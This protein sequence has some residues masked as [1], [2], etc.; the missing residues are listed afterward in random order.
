[1]LRRIMMKLLKQGLTRQTRVAA[2]AAMLCSIGICVAYG[3]E[4]VPITM[5]KLADDITVL[6][7]MIYRNEAP[8]DPATRARIGQQIDSMLDHVSQVQQS[9]AP[10]SD[11]YRISYQTLIMQLQQA[12]QELAK[13]RERHGI[14]L[15][16][17]ATS[18]CATCHMQ[19]ERSVNWLTPLRDEMND[20]F[21]AG[22]Y[23]FMTRQYERASSAYLSLL[24]QQRELEYD[25][26][27][28][29]AVDR[30]LVTSLQMQKDPQLLVKTLWELTEREHINPALR[31]DLSDWITGIAQLQQLTNIREHPKPDT[32]V[33]M[34]NQWINEGKNAPLGRIF[35]S[36]V[37]RPQIVWLRGELYHTLITATEREKIASLLYWL[38]LCDRVLEYRFYY[39]LADMYLKQCMLEYTDTPTAQQCYREYENYIVFSYSGSSGSNIPP[40]VDDEL[41]KLKATVF[42]IQS[43][44]KH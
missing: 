10:R 26:R 28:L 4:P 2:L 17:S 12:K 31:K 33:A 43:P 32:V 9:V 34:A 35:M 42:K 24:R 25:Q 29:T 21:V 8:A 7:P 36:E 11:T 13:G 14:Y 20:P 18:V 44:A 1:M 22:E 16:R 6:L 37:K 41:E 27:T 39:S 38:A 19:D 5:R 23:F 15:L 3:A 40:E 30:M